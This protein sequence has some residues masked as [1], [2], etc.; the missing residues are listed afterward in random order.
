MSLFRELLP[1]FV[2]IIELV[3]PDEMPTLNFRVLSTDVCETANSLLREQNS[4]FTCRDFTQI[5]PLLV[6]VWYWRRAGLIAAG[7][8]RANKKTGNVVDKYKFSVYV[9]HIRHDFNLQL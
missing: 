6:N 5:L 7:Y 3:A 9:S 2:R 4:V 8:F 1:R